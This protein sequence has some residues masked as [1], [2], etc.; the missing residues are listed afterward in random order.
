MSLKDELKKMIIET[1]NITDITPEEIN[2]DEP[3]FTEGLGLDSI[4]AL[5]LVVA[6]DFNYG[7]K[8]EDMETGKAAFASVSSLADF[9]EKNKK[10]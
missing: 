2:D 6:I 10:K 5:E 1:L 7:I 9:V 4:D 3:L 8:I